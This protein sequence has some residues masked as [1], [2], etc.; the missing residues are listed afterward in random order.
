MTK[1]NC[2]IN[3]Q[4]SVIKFL[5]LAKCAGY[6]FVAAAK[7][8]AGRRNPSNLKATQHA[9]GVFFYVAALAH[10]HFMVWQVGILCRSANRIFSIMVA[11]AGQLSG[12]PVIFRAGIP[13]PVWATTHE[14]RNS[15]G[16]VTRYLKEVAA[17]ATAPALLHSRFTYLFLAV[18]RSDS[19]SHPFSL[20]ITANSEREA[21][22]QL[23][24]EHVLCFAGRLPASISWEGKL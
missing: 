5:H 11:Q 24:R 20:R 22:L 2:A 23:I 8:V 6:S 16:S 19:S 4:F 3:S 15:G 17:M 13:T 7:S 21:R 18:R 12:W 9:P 1:L 10:L 14:R